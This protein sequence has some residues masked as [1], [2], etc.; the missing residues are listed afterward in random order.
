MIVE[1]DKTK[2]LDFVFPVTA[3]VIPVAKSDT[4]TIQF[5]LVGLSRFG[6]KIN[7]SSYKYPLSNEKLANFYVDQSLTSLKGTQVFGSGL[8]ISNFQNPKV[9]LEEKFIVVSEA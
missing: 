3:V 1:K 4:N 6:E 9:S 7:Y 5:R 2:L 8:P